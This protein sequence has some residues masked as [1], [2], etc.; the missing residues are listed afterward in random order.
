MSSNPSQEL[1][2]LIRSGWRLI[3]FETFEED[4][5][6]RILERVASACEKELITWSVALAT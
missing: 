6:L 2:L 1:S 5:A 4:R 3:A